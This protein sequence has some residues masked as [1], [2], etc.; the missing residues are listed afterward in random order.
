MSFT[1]PHLQVL[2]ELEKAGIP[3]LLSST[4]DAIVLPPIT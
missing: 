4:I 1:S 3:G 2:E